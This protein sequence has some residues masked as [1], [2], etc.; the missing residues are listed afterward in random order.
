T[1]ADGLCTPPASSPVTCHVVNTGGAGVDVVHVFADNNGTLNPAGQPGS[2]ATV[3][4]YGPAANVNLSPDSDSAA[5]GTCNAFSVKVTDSA[6]PGNGVPGQVVNLEATLTGTTTGRTLGFCNP[7]TT[8]P[9]ST[10]AGGD[11]TT[12]ANNPPNAGK[13]GTTTTALGTVTTNQNGDATFGIRSDQ[14][15]GA[16]VRAYVDKNSNGTFDAATEPSD[17]STKTFT[18]GGATGNAAQDAVAANGLTVSPPSQTAAVGDHVIYTVTARNGS[19]DTT[20]NVVINYKITGANPSTGALAATNNSGAATLD[21]VATNSGTDTVT[22]WV[23]QTTAAPATPNAD[24]GEPTATATTTIPGPPSGNTINL[25]CVGTIANTPGSDDDCV[26]PLT[27][28]SETF[29]ATVTKGGIAQAGIPVR[30]TI[31]NTTNPGLAAPVVFNTTTG[32]DGKAVFV[33]TDSAA[34]N[35]TK[36]TVVATI[37][38]QTVNESAGSNTDT[39][40]VTFQQAAPTTLNLTPPVLTTQTG[41]ASTFTA[42]V[43][44]QF[45]APVQGVNVDFSI[46]G[47]NAA[48]GGLLDKTTDVNGQASITY[49]D[50][51]NVNSPGTDTITAWADVVTEN[52]IHDAGEPT[53]SSTNNFITEPATAGS[54]DLDVTGTGTCGATGDPADDSASYN[55]AV[56]TTTHSVCALVK[57]AGGALLTGK[58]VTFTLTGVGSFVKADGTALASP[59]TVTTDASGV[60]RILVASTKSGAQNITAAINGK[61]DSGVVT[62]NAAATTAARFIDLTPNTS[63]LASGQN[64]ELTAT[65]TDV[66]GNPVSGITVDFT[67]SGGG[68]FT[69]GTSSQSGVTGPDGKVSVT[70]TSPAGTTGTDTV[71]A[72]IS[73]AQASASKC[74]LG[75]NN[76]TQGDKAGNCSDTS[77]YTFGNNTPLS[78]ILGTNVIA[79][80]QFTKVV[81]TGTPGDQVQILVKGAGAPGYTV[82]ANRTLNSGG[83]TALS[84]SPSTNSNYEV[85]DANGTV[86]PKFLLVKAV[87][88]INVAGSGGTGI[89]TGLVKP[90]VV[91]RVV[92]VYYYETGGHVA[93]ACKTLVQ[94][95]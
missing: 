9:T 39:G 82:I 68:N 36:D 32:S 26:E 94:P 20:P 88:S 85:R 18:A 11:D 14:P 90:S 48:V 89:F 72:A 4:F 24:A 60:A 58:D 63:T 76:P 23:N 83:G 7:G 19:G 84:I 34:V 57:T 3:T 40:S 47:R 53:D 69:N 17:T 35:G 95:G 21:Y 30:F 73:A 44:D 6:T 10:D 31:S 92:Y 49:T 64:H 8:N 86:G 13:V 42:T 75:A 16:T 74:G 77:T 45:G 5:A 55:P 29:T 70:L 2:D 43:T 62:Y 65:V 71:T 80:G 56:A 87:Q 12:P 59:Q 46:T 22:F 38:G 33:P 81:V 41:T 25:T 27:H 50:T 15:G 78:F 67:E 54:V 28:K 93:L 1:L 37:P 79:A 52:D 91:N 51:G 66:F 61:S